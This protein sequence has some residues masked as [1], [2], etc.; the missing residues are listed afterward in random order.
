MAE[1]KYEKMMLGR[2]EKALTDIPQA[3]RKTADI[4]RQQQLQTEDYIRQQE[5]RTAEYGAGLERIS[6]QQQEGVKRAGEE[7]QRGM[8]K[9]DYS[10]TREEI[11]QLVQLFSTLTAAAFLAGG[12]GRQSGMGALSAMTGAMEGYRKGQKEV[13]DREI[14]EFDKRLREVQL[15]NEGVKRQYDIAMRTLQ[16]NREAGLAE[17]KKLEMMATNSKMAYDARRGDLNALA[18]DVKTQV[19]AS[20]KAITDWATYTRQKNAEARAQEQLRIS[21]KRLEIAEK[22]AT[23]GRATQ[24]QFI[25]QRAVNALG[26]VES[27]LETIVALPAGSTTGWLPNLQTKDGMVNAIRNQ[28]GRKIAPV[29]AEFMNTL[30][31]GIGRNLATIEA[32][33]LASGLTTL[34]SQLQSGVY[35]NAGVDDPYKVAMKLADIRR[36]ATENIRPAI[37]SGLMPQKQAEEAARL[38]GKIEKTIPYTTLD[39]ANA[40]KETKLPSKKTIGRSVGETM[41][42]TPATT[43][44]PTAPQAT[45]RAYMGNRPIVVRDNKWVYED[46]GEEVK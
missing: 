13:F 22:N 10:P 14:K 28:L 8:M 31:S 24:Q 5:A 11:P 35:I 12:K 45:P 9:V 6:R 2:A 1:N 30:F 7:Y 32:S 26:G 34:A 23:G 29:D 15:H 4:R 27:A 17:L 38:V 33:G 37:N 16:T 43:A 36:I 40:Y 42:K 19:D 44:T 41:A 25:V 20:N 18:Q 21:Q 3:E 39:V 46:T